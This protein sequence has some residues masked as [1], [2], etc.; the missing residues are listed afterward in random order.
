MR[1]SS[2]LAV[3]RCL[4]PLHLRYILLSSCWDESPE[5]RP[6]FVILVE[7]FRNIVTNWRSSIISDASKPE[8]DELRLSYEQLY[9]DF[10]GDS[11]NSMTVNL[12][13]LGGKVQ[14]VVFSQRN[15]AHESVNSD[16]SSGN[17]SHL[18]PVEDS[19]VCA[20]NLYY[21]MT[22]ERCDCKANDHSHP[23]VPQGVP[24]A[25]SCGESSCPS[26]PQE[27][28]TCCMCEHSLEASSS[29]A[30][31]SIHTSGEHTILED[32]GTTQD[33][34][35][36]S[37]QLQI[38]EEKMKKRKHSSTDSKKPR[39]ARRHTESQRPSRSSASSRP[40]KL[41]VVLKPRT[42]SLPHIMPYLSPVKCDNGN[43]QFSLDDREGITHFPQHHYFVLEQPQP[44]TIALI[45]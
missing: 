26:T 34:N 17:Y 9:S 30:N 1:I 10:S 15:R 36:S 33:S 19:R 13:S 8:D 39:G 12:D 40:T 42:E 32:S 38:T 43:E 28:C 37:R 29:S 3:S 44:K 45:S 7:S 23:Q 35:S 41:P 31:K 25:Y 2:T 4:S 22:Q 18:A 20:T 16:G 6:C 27:L 5:M 21:N 14:E 11:D 24:H